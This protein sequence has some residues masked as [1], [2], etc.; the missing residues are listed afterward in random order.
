MITSAIEGAH[1][2]IKRIIH[3]PEGEEKTLLFVLYLCSILVD[4]TLHAREDSPQSLIIKI[5]LTSF[6]D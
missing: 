5:S 1:E 3:L 6:S 4:L 2:E